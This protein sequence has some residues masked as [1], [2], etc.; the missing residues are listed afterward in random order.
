MT[1]MWA[2]PSTV[3]GVGRQPPLEQGGQVAL[4]EAAGA[5]ELTD[6]PGVVL[7]A[8]DRE[9]LARGGPEGHRLVGHRER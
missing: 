6:D 8:H 4:V 1:P 7:A 9:A 2:P 3:D 5:L